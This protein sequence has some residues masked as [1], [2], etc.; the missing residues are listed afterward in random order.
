MHVDAENT[1]LRETSIRAVNKFEVLEDR[2]VSPEFAQLGHMHKVAGLIW[3]GV[4]PRIM[5]QRDAVAYC[6]S[7]GGGARLPTKDEY[8]ALSRA[9]GVRQPDFTAPGF[10]LDGYNVNL[11]SDM[12]ML[13]GYPATFASASAHPKDRSPFYSPF[14][15]RHLD[16]GVYVKEFYPNED[17]RLRLVR[18]VVGGL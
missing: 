10:N 14:Y 4:A 9:M 12:K 5:D 8:I 16:G 7:L 17:I 11:I 1:R 3:S 15:F 6:A 2:R 18:C 13:D